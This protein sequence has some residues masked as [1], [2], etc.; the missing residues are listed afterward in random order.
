[1]KVYAFDVDDTLEVSRGPISLQSVL[2]LKA[3][4][5]IIGICGNWFALVQ[6]GPDWLNI[7]SFVGPSE[8]TKDHFLRHTARVIEADEYIMVGNIFGVTGASDDMGAAEHAGWRFNSEFD[9]AAGQ[10]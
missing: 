3:Q 1:M 5:H 7:A 4:G 10:R 2:E 9:F 8:S 6:K